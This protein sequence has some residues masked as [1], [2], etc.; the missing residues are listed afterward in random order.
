MRS[1]VRLMRDSQRPAIPFDV[2]ADFPH[3]PVLASLSGAQLKFSVRRDVDGVHRQAGDLLAERAANYASCLAVVRWACPILQEK[4]TQP[5]YQGL[6]HAAALRKLE[7]N[8]ITD[9]GIQEPFRSWILARVENQL[10]VHL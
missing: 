8:L 6:S 5:K 10:T 7:A 3:Y 2:P 1:I 9:F 4:L